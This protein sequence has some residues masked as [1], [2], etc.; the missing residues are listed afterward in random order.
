LKKVNFML[1]SLLYVINAHQTLAIPR[2]IYKEAFG[3][4]NH[5]RTLADAMISI[6]QS[7]AKLISK[8]KMN[9]FLN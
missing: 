6:I 4:L 9:F 1:T 5:I 7:L 8:K 3:S 2:G